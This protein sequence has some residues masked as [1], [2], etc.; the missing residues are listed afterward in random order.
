MTDPPLL[1]ADDL[2]KAWDG[3]EVL[4]GLSLTVTAGAHV[5]VEGVSGSGKSTLLNVL[6]RLVRPDRGTV[7]Y[8]RVSYGTLG[9]PERFRLNHVG[10]VFQEVQLLDSMSVAANIELVQAASGKPPIALR[11]LLGPL[12]LFHRA[13]DRAAVLSRGERQKVALARAFANDPDLVLAD[14]PTASLDP[15]NRDRT[16]DQLFALCARCNATAVVVSHDRDVSAR[17]EFAQ[18]CALVDGALQSRA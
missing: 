13:S 3:I 9:R 5:A 10:L 14:E 18:R 4:R 6:A 17:P 7:A 11:D 2:A 8:R 1:Q 15:S 16:L 12:G